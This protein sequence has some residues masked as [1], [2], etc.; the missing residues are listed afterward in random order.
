M[1][2]S[3]DPWLAVLERYPNVAVVVYDE[4]EFF[5]GS[6]LEDW[7]KTGMWRQSSRHGMVHL[8]DYWRILSSYRGGGFYMDLDVIT[9]KR[10]DQTFLW[11]FFSLENW[12]GM[13]F[14][15][16]IFHM[17][18][19]HW[20]VSAMVRQL[21][22]KSYDPDF[23]NAY[24]PLFVKEAMETHCSLKLPDLSTNV[25]SDVTV[26]PSRHFFPIP[27]QEWHRYWTE[28]DNRTAVMKE[29]T[30]RGFGVHVWNKFSGSQTLVKG[31][32]A[33]YALLAAEHCPLTFAATAVDSG[34]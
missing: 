24:G 8:T 17:E 22:A 14:C 20:L 23:Y 16:G 6:P 30:E 28:Q 3:T 10:L 33:L 1:D 27:H 4:S 25:C 31:S 13:D 29:M 12:A 32:K 15:S 2:Y 9:F 7:Y 5:S 26:L 18:H 34:P 19:G 11:N 21:A